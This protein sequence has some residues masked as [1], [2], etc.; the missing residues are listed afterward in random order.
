MRFQ[1]DPQSELYGDLPRV[2]IAGRPNAGKS[3]LFNRLA[4]KR[5]AITDPTPG[6]TRDAIETTALIAGKP[7]KLIDTGGFKLE[8]VYDKENEEQKQIDTIVLERTLETLKTADL[9]ILLFSAGE[10]NAEDEELINLMRVL[11]EKTIVCVNKTEGGRL[12]AESYDLYKY[13][14]KELFFIS[15]EHGDNIP[16][17]CDVIA[18]KLDFSHIKL[19]KP[20]LNIIKIAI[21]GKPNT[22]KSTFF[23]RLTSTKNSLVSDI[24]GTTRDVINGEFF[25]NEY[26]FIVL[27][28]AGIRRKSKIEKTIEYYSVNRAIKAIEEADIVLH[29][30]DAVEGFTEQDKKIAALANERG[31]GIIFILNKW[32]LV[33]HIK[34]SFNAMRDRLHFI[35]PHM[36]FSPVLPLCA[37]DGEGASRIL[38]TAIVIYKQ[39]KHQIETSVFNN[40]LEKWQNECHP[41]SGPRTRFKIKYGLQTCVNPVLFKLFVSRPQVWTENYAAFIRNKIRKDLGFSMV[42]VRLD[43]MPSRERRQK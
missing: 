31:K 23:N 16:E 25:Y 41:P 14:F 19:K 1:S 3:T 6:V 38:D 34:N 27:D 11:L 33:K 17:L 43:V 4:H 20:L 39:L 32:D 28:T 35:F 9:I 36:N 40:Y 30:I 26:K 5:R 24:A 2:V 8:R 7:V 29:L 21:A 15:A 18:S 42:P 13:G 37:K 22:G 12:K 10:I